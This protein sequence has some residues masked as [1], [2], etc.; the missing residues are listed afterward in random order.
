MR[1]LRLILTCT[2][3]AAVPALAQGQRARLLVTVADTTGAVIPEAKVSVVGLE[4]ATKVVAVQP[5]QTSAVGVATLSGLVTGRYTIV[6][7]FSGFEPGML[8]D[9]RI[10]T[11]DN[12]HI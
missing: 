5:V 8:R 9:V 4:E 2:L 11:G 1:L 6:A 12:K 10:R 7:E 3:V